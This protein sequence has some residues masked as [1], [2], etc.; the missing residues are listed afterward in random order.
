MLIKF[1][2][3]DFFSVKIEE[4]QCLH[5]VIHN[6]TITGKLCYLKQ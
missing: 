6:K 5:L 3:T 4:Y 1:M 2:G